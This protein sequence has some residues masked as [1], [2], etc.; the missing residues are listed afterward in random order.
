MKI[1]DHIS[2]ELLA[3]FGLPAPEQAP[4][5]VLVPAGEIERLRAENEQLLDKVNKAEKLAEAASNIISWLIILNTKYGFKWDDELTA[6]VNILNSSI[7]DFDGDDG[8]NDGPI[9][10]VLEV[11]EVT[12]DDRET[13]SSERP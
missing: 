1:T 7:G 2:K 9:Q 10:F 6:R 3:K 13:R 12:E 5:M 4:K 8:S 11:S